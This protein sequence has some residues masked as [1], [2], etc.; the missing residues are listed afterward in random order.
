[1]KSPPDH[2][3]PNLINACTVL[4]LL[5]NLPD[6]GGLSELARTSKLPRTTTYRILRS[7]R[8]AGLVTEYDNV[9]RCGPGLVQLGLA[10]MARVDLR[11]AGGPA[12]EELST[13]TGETSQLVLPD[14]RSVFI[15]DTR[16]SPHPVK[17]TTR[18]GTVIPVHCSSTGKVLLA[19]GTPELVERLSDGMDLTART[20]RTITSRTALAH[21]L[22]RIR[23][24][25]YAVDDGEYDPEVRCIA[26]PVRGVHGNVIAAIGITAT[27]NRLRKDM[28]RDSARL[29]MQS[30]SELSRALGYVESRF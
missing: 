10:A 5:A 4:R 14:Q 20:S 12:L 17:P 27:S 16:E 15:F 28:V 29:V 9:W 1:M 3:I 6:G 19:F 13:K 18:P 11:T 30:A 2:T 23:Q 24:Q 8:H 22:E 7:F 25:G 21:E 26:A